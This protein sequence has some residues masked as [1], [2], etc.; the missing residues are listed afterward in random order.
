MGYMRHHGM[1]V[2]SWQPEAIVKA[3]NK[4]IK[5]GLAVTDITPSGING[6]TTFAVVPDGSKEGWTPSELGDLA[7]DKYVTWLRGCYRKGLYLSWVEI[8]Y[9]DEEGDTHIVNHSDDEAS[10]TTAPERRS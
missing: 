9:G 7:R 10:Y 1:L 6:Y 5:L 8:Q 3:H 2:T 4:A